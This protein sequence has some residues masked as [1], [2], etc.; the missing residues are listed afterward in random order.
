MPTS[1][2]GFQTGHN[3]PD[4]NPVEK[5]ATV[6]LRH[7]SFKS[8]FKVIHLHLVLVFTSSEV[9]CAAG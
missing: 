8:I 2:A 6:R 3:F 9:T 1:G 7:G 5:R 4:G